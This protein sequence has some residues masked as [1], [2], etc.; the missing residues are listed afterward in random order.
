MQG[1][2]IHVATE[3]ADGVIRAEDDKRYRYGVGDWASSERAAIGS[4]VDF[5][6]DDERAK[7]IYCVPD[8]SDVALAGQANPSGRKVP[9]LVISGLLLALGIGSLLA[10]QSGMFSSPA[11]QGPLKTYNVTGLAKVRNLPTTQGSIVVRDLQ[12]GDSF[13]GRVYLGPDGQSQWIKREGSEEYV[14]IINLA[15]SEPKR[16][17][18]VNIPSTSQ[19][20]AGI[21]SNGG[22]QTVVMSAVQNITSYLVSGKLRLPSDMGAGLQCLVDGSHSLPPDAGAICREFKLVRYLNIGLT[23]ADRANGI[24]SSYRITISMVRWSGWNNRFEDKCAMYNYTILT[25]EQWSIQPNA[26]AESNFGH[27]VC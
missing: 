25:N 20:L 26:A 27:A 24:S 13:S 8:G 18:P 21:P 4:S 23:S 9:A 15:E 19:S 12:P 14:S 7:S 22:D 10:Y 17:A 5:E 3:D 6:V 2:V 11:S 1:K 16:V